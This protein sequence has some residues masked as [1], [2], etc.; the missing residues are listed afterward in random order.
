VRLQAPRE[1]AATIFEPFDRGGRDAADPVPGV[2]L[3]LAL[4]R[5]LA[6]DRGGELTLERPRDG[7][8]CFRLELPARV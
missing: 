4:S 1:R 8:A 5:D 3:G 7:G 2:G 6:R